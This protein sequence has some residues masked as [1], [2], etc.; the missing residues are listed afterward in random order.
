MRL[1]KNISFKTQ[2]QLEEATR[3]QMQTAVSVKYEVSRAKVIS[4]YT[5]EMNKSLMSFRNHLILLWAFAL[6]FVAYEFLDATNFTFI[7]DI[8]K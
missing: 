7:L 3:K 1:F 5:L 2:A 8:L 4:D 6:S